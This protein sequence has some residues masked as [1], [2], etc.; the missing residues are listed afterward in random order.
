MS[1]IVISYASKDKDLCVKMVRCLSAHG[2]WDV[3]WDDAIR[4]DRPLS[5]AIRAEI[6]QAKAVVVLWT[7]QSVDS[8]WVQA[9]AETARKCGNL[10]SVR[11]G[12]KT[13]D[14]PMPF[15]T[16]H[17]LD[18]SD[19]KGGCDSQGIQKLLAALDSRI[20]TY[21]PYTS[22]SDPT[23]RELGSHPLALPFWGAFL[24]AAGGILAV[25]FGLGIPINR[26]CDPVTDLAQPEVTRLLKDANDYLLKGGAADSVEVYKKV[27][28]KV[29]P[30]TRERLKAPLGD[31]E[32]LNAGGNLEGAA[33]AYQRTYENLSR[34]QL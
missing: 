29:C 4:L 30:V 26:S 2:G 34:S 3:W 23:E 9:E 24:A 25:G 7:P 5:G 33:R 15:G 31:A 27:H 19:W 8:E 21:A 20:K 14:I 22:S 10:I 6:R 1:D 18:L 12:G 32:Q 11:M 16:R 28:S 13:F 17:I